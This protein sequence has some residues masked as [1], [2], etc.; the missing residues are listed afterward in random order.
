MINHIHVEKL[1]PDMRSCSCTKSFREIRTKWMELENIMLGEITQKEHT[2]H[3][4]TDK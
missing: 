1:C 3:V 4:L 2:W